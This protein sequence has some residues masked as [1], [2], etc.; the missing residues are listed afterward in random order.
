MI[1]SNK[2]LLSTLALSVAFSS[3]C[4]KKSGGDE[5]VADSTGATTAI[6]V[7]GNQP[8]KG[9]VVLNQNGTG[10]GGGVFSSVEEADTVPPKLAANAVISVNGYTSTEISLSW[11][12]ATDNS[13]SVIYD[14]YY[15]STQTFAS[16]A[17]L[18]KPGVLN[19]TGLTSPNVSLKNLSPDTTYN[20][21]VV[22]RDLLGNSTLYTA[23]VQTAE[24]QFQVSTVTSE[25]TIVG[26]ATTL[27]SGASAVVQLKAK[28]LA[29]NALS[30]GG[31][32][33]QFF[34]TGGS[35][36]FSQ[37]FPRAAADNSDGTYTIPITGLLAGSPVTIGATIGGVATTSTT[38]I[39]VVPGPISAVTSVVSVAGGATSVTSGNGIV[40][41]VQAKDAAGNNLTSGGAT[42]AFTQAGGTS[43]FSQSF[44][45]SASN[46]G[47]GTYTAT[48]TGVTSGSARTIGATINGTSSTLT[49]SLQ[50]LPGT[51]SAT[52]SLVD[53]VQGVSSVANG[54]QVTLRLRAR[55]AA[56]NFLTSGGAAVAFTK[57]GG[58]STFVQSFALGATDNGDG[59][60]TAQVTGNVAGSAATIGATIGV[61]P[62][63]STVSLS[64]SS[65]SISTATSTVSIVGGATTVASGTNV[66]VRLQA[67]DSS[68]NNLSAGGSTVTFTQTGGTSTF[69]QGFPVAATDNGDGTYSATITGVAVGTAKT[70]GA[71]IGGSAV[72]STTTLAVVPGT[73]T[74]AQSTVNIVG[75]ATSVASGSNVTVRLQAKD[76]NGNNL[77]SG[78][79]T[80]AFTQTGGTAT[81]TQSF[82]LSATDNG[83]GTYSA[84]ITGNL[85][86]SAKTLGATIGGSAVTSTTALSVT[87]GTISAATS[88]VTIVGGATT[89]ASGSDVTVRLQAKDAAGNDL[90]AGGA[91]VAFTTTGGTSTYTQSFPLASNDVGDGTYTA[92]LTGLLSGTATTIN[93]TIGA[94]TSTS[95]TTLSVTPGAISTVTSVVSVVGGATTVA[96]GSDVTLR[97]QAKDAA[98]NN[99]T[100]GGATVVFTKT[101]GT[102]D[103][104]ISGTTDNGDGTYTATFTGTTSGSPKTI[105]ATIGGTPATSTTSLQTVPG[106]M[107]T[108]T[109]IVSASASTVASGSTV[110]IKVDARDAQ[111]NVITTGGATVAFTVT[112]GSA[113]FAES[114]PL[115]ATDNGDGTY[116][117][118]ITGQGAGTA[119]TIGA[120][121]GGSAVT[122]TTTVDVNSNVG[123]N[124]AG[125]PTGTNNATSLNVTVS[126]TGVVYYKHKVGATG[127]TDCSSASG[128]GSE[129][130]VGTHITNNISGVPDGSVTLCVIGADAAHN[131]QAESSAATATWTKK[132]TPPSFTSLDLINEAADGYLNASDHALTNA[133]AGN[134]Q[135]AAYTSAGYK[136]VSSGTACD[137]ALSYG[138][139][140]LE[141][142]TSDMSSD[143]TYKVCVRLVDTAGNSPAYGST[144][145][146]VLKTSTIGFTAAAL[147]NEAVG[148][149]INAAEHLLTSNLV[150]A[151]TGSNFDT[152]GYILV[153][154]GTTCNVSL[155]YGAI[156]KND[157]T[158]FSGDGAFKVC[159]KLTDNAGNTPAYGNSS[160]INYKGSSPSF[161]GLALA[162]DAADFYVNA[163]EKTANAAI[164]SAAT[165]A[166]FDTA[167]Y[168]V[169][170]VPTTCDGGLSYGAIPTANTLGADDVYKVCVRL[171]DAAGNPAAYNSSSNFMLKTSQ[172]AFTSLTRGTDAADGY[173]NAAEKLLTNALATGISG[174]DYHT[175]EYKLTTNATAC[176]SIGTYGS[177]P[178]DNSS[179][180]GSDG[181]YKVCAKLT[182]NAGNTP[183]YGST[184]AFSL[185][186]SL[187]TFSSLALANEAADGYVNIADR[188][189]TNALAGSLS[190]SGTDIAPDYA[191][192]TS[193]TTCSGVGS[194]GSMPLDNS[195][196]FGSD[197]T[198]K[199]CV[200]LR[201][202]AGNTTAY[203]A[204]STMTLD[205]AAP[206]VSL[207]SATTNPTNANPIAVTATFSEAVTL[208]VSGDVTPGNATL[209]GFSGSGTTYT[210]NLAPT[211]ASVTANVAGSVAIDAAGNP[212]SA[213]TQFSRTYDN[214]AP[215]INGGVTSPDPDATYGVAAVI[216]IT[217]GFSEAVTVTGTPLLAMNTTPP[218]NASY[219]SGSGTSTLTFR[220]TATSGDVSNDLDYASTGALTLN[221]GTIKDPAGNNATLTL[222]TVGGASSLGGSKNIKIDT[223]AA[224]INSVTATVSGPYKAGSV[225]PIQVEFDDVVT[226]SGTG[227]PEITLNTS[228]VQKATY[229]GMGTAPDDNIMNFQYTVQ[230]G[231]TAGLLDYVNVNSLDMKSRTLTDSG[232]STAITVLPAVGGG[233]SLEQSNV[234]I[235]TTAP[236]VTGVTTTTPDSTYSVGFQVDVQVAFSE[237]VVVSGSP[238]IQL[239]VTNSGPTTRYATYSSGSGTGTLTFSYIVQGPN[240]ASGDQS[241]E[242]EYS[243]TSALALNGGS[244]DDQASNAATLTLPSPAAAGS[245]SANS[246]IVIDASQPPALG[247]SGVSCCALAADRT[248]AATEMTVQYPADISQYASVN[249]YRAL[250][251][252]APDADC[253]SGTLVKTY[254]SGFSPGLQQTFI[255]KTSNPGKAYSYRVCAM[256]SGSGIVGTATATNITATVMH[257]VFTTKNPVSN[258]NLGGRSG[259]DATCQ[260]AGNSIDNT[261]T[262]V[263]LLSDTANEMKGTPIA[264]P[265]YNR[266]STPVSLA[267]TYSGFYAAT[268]NTRAFAEDSTSVTG[269]AWTGATTGALRASAANRCQNGGVDWTNGSS[270]NGVPGTVTSTSTSWMATTTTGCTSS[271]LRLMCLSKAMEPLVSFSTSTPTSG[272]IGDVTVSIDFP[273]D[274]TN[275]TKVELKRNRPTWNTTTLQWNSPSCTAGTLA[276]TWPGPTFTDETFTDETALPGQYFMYTVCVYTGAN[277]AASYTTINKPTKTYG[278][279][280]VSTIFLTA[281]TQNG[282]FSGYSGANGL[283]KADAFCQARGDT[284]STGKT[285]KAILSTSTVSAASRISSS[286]EIRNLAGTLVA[287]NYAD[288][289]DNALAAGISYQDTFAT[290]TTTQIFTGTTT[291]GL[292]STAHCTDWTSSAAGGA[293]G[294]G[295]RG[296]AGSATGTWIGNTGSTTNCN[297]ARRIWCIAATPD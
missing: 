136:L 207:T 292:V 199:V 86:G 58:S 21:I 157:S 227:T 130:G 241:A 30:V 106:A 218:R 42:V 2:L 33:V 263:A 252:S 208:F 94:A 195:G 39:Q 88:T 170:T 230:A 50:V 19:K 225:I 274:T 215:T 46:N 238:R 56:N 137:G 63:T 226:I 70:L 167:G 90:S 109:S 163:A 159:V 110:Q 209:S 132:A 258:G 16:A 222:P 160:T 173:I 181:S 45:V 11:T 220:Y 200:R 51:I 231:D 232:G 117:A 272:T 87:V 7:T 89:V 172:P 150:S 174:S 99:R 261:L 64:V 246:T 191:L 100:V 179:D 145:N 143:G 15:S 80:V 125:Q 73:I 122:S 216:S 79:S 165:G 72:T 101:G 92:T 24:V 126:G 25:V 98:G 128:Y 10:G 108:A 105:G 211:G 66:T 189:L 235:D 248:A 213:A 214:T 129:T 102:G 184:T 37:S 40:V 176:S 29:G 91:T 205:T 287:N 32:D 152:A 254:S 104:T 259:A 96:S 48:L 13:G 273:A 148:G 47:D 210:F 41:R 57:S 124:I 288:L 234:E 17:D 43:T 201:D 149:Y 249:V 120:T 245:L 239:N 14:V 31:E 242:L 171:T 59:T 265:V 168:V 212:N 219:H 156:P 140:P 71:T 85:V 97:L 118:N 112:G 138:A 297:N 55:D 186:T 69:S 35:S 175:V 269:S 1:W 161:S 107:A 194:W 93:A 295:S 26:G 233:N 228:P 154:S 6:V 119:K 251:T 275:W 285:W 60:Y 68:G 134:L 276:K 142:N 187:P 296:S 76:V 284:F 224:K 197:G 293:G 178:L 127:S 271:T 267:S 253:A 185:D 286:G 192:V 9:D 243:S 146:F 151:A 36:T 155:T 139:M 289:F 255:D 180:F 166:N 20:I 28:D 4:R 49:T 279:G 182:D 74:T 78:G 281:T 169:A 103:G 121:I 294:T 12:A 84:T 217:I 266:A 193:A 190:S 257:W 62:V 277:V 162:N 23:I 22:A 291:A 67:K 34:L 116:T 247:I 153:S 270:G 177:M 82:P 183:A 158:V 135:G 188:L 144:S 123:A 81:F 53:V 268:S 27:A 244:I 115:A 260:A 44:P 250:G 264:G 141:N 280:T 111:N 256:D 114:F 229:T 131:Y 133:I 65:G 290:S 3:A 203:G 5:E 202:N 283:A 240:S 83:D 8:V 278:G 282:A 147:A 198:Y 18:T 75:G 236:T 206:S 164:V 204:S 52:T 77:T 38:T 237:V 61:T 262:W 223:V 54:S 196:S 95:S 113:T 221:G